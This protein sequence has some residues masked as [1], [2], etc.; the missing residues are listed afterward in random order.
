MFEKTR[1]MARKYGA[2]L[3]AAPAAAMASF[4][5]FAQSTGPGEDI[6]TKVTGGMTQGEKI[7]SAVVLGLFAIWVVKLLW[8]SK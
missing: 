5:A 3:V 8:R 4:G 7:A 6:L 2:R 1:V